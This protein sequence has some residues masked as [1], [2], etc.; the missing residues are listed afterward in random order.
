[1]KMLYLA[2]VQNTGNQISGKDVTG[3]KSIVILEDS[4]AI[5]NKAKDAI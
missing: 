1:M 2:D 4:L 5:S 3:I